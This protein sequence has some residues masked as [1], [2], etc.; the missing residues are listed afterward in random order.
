MLIDLNMD[1]KDLSIHIHNEYESLI[2]SCIVHGKLPVQLFQLTNIFRLCLTK[3]T[4]PTQ[5]FNLLL[6][7]LKQRKGQDP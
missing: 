1:I 6:I 7:L 3:I 2:H 5:Q 4:F